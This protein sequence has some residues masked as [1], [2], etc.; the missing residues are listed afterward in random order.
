[1]CESIARAAGILSSE[2]FGK[3]ATPQAELDLT[4]AHLN[5]RTIVLF[6]RAYFLLRTNES[7]VN[8]TYLK[9][10]LC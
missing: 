8:C 4:L 2:R 7:V 5:S 1:M 3:G 6:R 9:C 10:A